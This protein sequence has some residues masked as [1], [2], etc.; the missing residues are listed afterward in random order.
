MIFSVRLSQKGI[1]DRLDDSRLHYFGWSSVHRVADEGGVGAKDVWQ[2]SL[3]PVGLL[4]P[5]FRLVGVGTSVPSL[6]RS[7]SVSLDASSY[8]RCL[9]A[10]NC[11]V[12]FCM[13]LCIGTVGIQPC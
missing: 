7:F 11:T 13:T 1:K 10:S 8:A 3:A 9:L 2:T 12:L 4:R 5:P 6:R